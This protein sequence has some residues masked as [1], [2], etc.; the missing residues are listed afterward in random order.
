MYQSYLRPMETFD[1]P[2]HTRHRDLG[3]TMG[4]FEGSDFLDY[5]YFNREIRIILH[6]QY[7]MP[8]EAQNHFF[9]CIESNQFDIDP[10]T[11][12]KNWCDLGIYGPRK[13][14]YT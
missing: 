3:L 2:F 1:Y 6:S 13:V 12:Q 11:T 9:C 4:I 5:K 7:E 14:E 8:D 10:A